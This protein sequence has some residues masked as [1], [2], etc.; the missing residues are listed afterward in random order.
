MK[1][2]K[3]VHHTYVAMIPAVKDVNN[4]YYADDHAQNWRDNE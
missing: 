1:I 4:S 2:K 3:M